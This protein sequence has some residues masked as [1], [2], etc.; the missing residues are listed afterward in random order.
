VRGAAGHYAAHRQFAVLWRDSLPV[1]AEEHKMSDPYAPQPQQPN[2]PNQ[3]YSGQPYYPQQP[4]QYPAQPGPQQYGGQPNPSADPYPAQPYGDPYAA[5]QQGYPQPGY[6]PQI[7]AGYPP[8]PPVKK[9]RTG[10]IVGVVVIVVALAACS[11]I[12]VIAL[13]F[14]SDDKT[15]SLGAKPTGT[16]KPVTLKAPATIGTLKKSSDQSRA[17]TLSSA[18]TNAGLENPFAAVYQDTKNPGRNVVIWGGTGA[19]FNAGGAQRQL[20]SFF[21]SM[22]SQLAGTKP[23]AVEAGAIGGKAECAKSGLS[24]LKISICAWVGNGALL[25]FIFNA[26]EPDAAGAQMRT[27]LP[28]IVAKG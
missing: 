20:D 7:P 25:G 17:Q 22:S 6:G 11:G 2:Q 13:K 24:G 28:S 8:Q 14:G 5:Q 19:I 9:R 3:P 18:M 23:V 21:S 1:A 27:I 16:A 15:T 4:P 12:A 26:V 10:L